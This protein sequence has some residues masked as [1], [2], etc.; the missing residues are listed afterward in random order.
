MMGK[1]KSM[2]SK[3]IRFLKKKEEEFETCVLCSCKTNIKLDKPVEERNGY[4][5]GVG[6]LCYKCYKKINFR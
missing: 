1:G 5:E 6:Q 2:K 4:V 3:I